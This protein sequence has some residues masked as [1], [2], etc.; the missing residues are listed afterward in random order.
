MIFTLGMGCGVKFGSISLPCWNELVLAGLCSDS[1]PS[2][3]T[4]DL[5]QKLSQGL[6]GEGDWILSLTRRMKVGGL[7]GALP[8]LTRIT[9]AGV[10]ARITHMHLRRDPFPAWGLQ[11][12][13]QH[14]GQLSG[15][16][17]GGQWQ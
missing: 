14:Q 13:D 1:D 3:G 8:Y 9:D 4:E 10:Q 7:E 15:L 5:G 6:L 11:N 16:K 12:R 2:P 17:T